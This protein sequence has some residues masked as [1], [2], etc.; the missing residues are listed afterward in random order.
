MFIDY[1]TLMLVNMAAGC[2]YMGVDRI[3]GKLAAPAAEITNQFCAKRGY[4]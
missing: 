2:C 1:V 4:K 3:H